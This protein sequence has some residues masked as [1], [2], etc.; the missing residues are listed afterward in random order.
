MADGQ[1]IRIALAVAVLV[2]ASAGPAIAQAADP[3]SGAVT[4]TAGIDFPSVYFFRG[5]RQEIDPKVTMFP[6]G[7]VSIALFSGDGG[8]KS[9]SVNFGV[10]NSL[11]TGTSGSGGPGAMHYEEIFYASLSLGFGAGVTITPQFT[12]Y[13]SPN[14]VFKTVKEISFKV[15]HASK[16]APYGLVAFEVGG[17]NSGQADD[18]SE[19]GTYAELGVA[20]SWGIGVGRATVAIP[21]KLGLSVKDYYEGLAGDEGFGYLD[22]GVLFTV[23]LSGVSSNY[24]S[25]NVHGGANYLRLGDSTVL[26][27]GNDREQNQFVV[28]AG[29]GF[30]Y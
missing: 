8:V 14:Q 7:D 17:T 11:H 20:P 2:S 13:T 23:P 24:G 16:Y 15:A 3:N 29:I 12:A 18:G 4:L 1:L 21:L 27:P 22:A 5:I 28:S 9:G 25:W 30:T 26:I 10:W 19:K 6:Y